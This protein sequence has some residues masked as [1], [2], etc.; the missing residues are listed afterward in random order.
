MSSSKRPSTSSLRRFLT[1]RPYVP[2]AEIR[3]RFGID[4]P[5][6]MCRVERGEETFFVGLPEREAMKVQ[7]LWLRGEIGLEQS[8]EVHAPVVV[9]V[10]PMRIARYLVDGSS[11]GHR[12][13]LV[14]AG[15]PT[16]RAGIPAHGGNGAE[17][18]MPTRPHTTESTH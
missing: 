14:E 16:D 7:E 12:P 8:V 15:P 9:G 3:R 17:Q 5:D 4:D 13:V 6:C 11:N 2:V 10:Y 1:S 18:R